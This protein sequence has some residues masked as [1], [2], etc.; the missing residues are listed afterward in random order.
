[1]YIYFYCNYSTTD[2]SILK[3]KLLMRTLKFLFVFFILA[4]HLGCDGGDP[5]TTDYAT[6]RIYNGLSDVPLLSAKNGSTE[7][8]ANLNYEARSAPF[9]VKTTSR[10]TVGIY[11]QGGVSPIIQKQQT[12]SKDENLFWL[13]LGRA[14]TAELLSINE[15][16]QTPPT[17]KALVRFVLGAKS[18]TLQYSLFLAPEGADFESV[19]IWAG[20]VGFKT[21]VPYKTVDPGK[22]NLVILNPSRNF[23][24]K[25]LTIGAGDVRTLILAD[26]I[27]NNDEFDLVNLKD[28]L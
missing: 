22:Y 24:S 9:Q 28:N 11:R 27:N 13:L 17:G 10:Q 8:V 25:T 5:V 26:P 14:E 7:V 18:T 15:T 1:M 4:I 19:L 16:S 20:N 21:L 2:N 12:F 3:H 23:T 6:I